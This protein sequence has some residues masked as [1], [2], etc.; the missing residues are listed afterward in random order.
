MYAASSTVLSPKWLPFVK[1]FY[2]YIPFREAATNED[3]EG[4]FMYLLVELIDAELCRRHRL[5]GFMGDQAD[6]GDMFLGRRADEQEV[7]SWRYGED[8][9]NWVIY[10]AGMKASI[11]LNRLSQSLWQL[12]TLGTCLTVATPG[13][14]VGLF[15][16]GFTSQSALTSA[17]LCLPQKI[18]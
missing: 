15:A 5:G 1:T 17:Q 11:A 9:E 7:K 18:G 14:V 13:M 10:L 16:C 12:A 2:Y 3:E 6:K 4:F 8:C